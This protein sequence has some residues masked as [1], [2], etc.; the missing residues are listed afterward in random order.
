MIARLVKERDEARALLSSL[1]V[2]GGQ[3][4]NGSGADDMDVAANESVAGGLG[5]GVIEVIRI[6]HFS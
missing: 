4:I 5:A 2:S 6:S 1:Q 3:M